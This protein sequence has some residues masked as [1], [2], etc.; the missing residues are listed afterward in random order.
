MSLFYDPQKRQPQAWV[1]PTFIIVTI[2]LAVGL[3]QWG[4]Q[5]AK[6]KT[7]NKPAEVDIFSK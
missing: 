5:K 1:I 2:V 6:E 3:Y 4:Q 7:A